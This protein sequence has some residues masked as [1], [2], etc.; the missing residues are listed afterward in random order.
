MFSFFPCL[1]SNAQPILLQLVTTLY[2]D[3]TTLCRQ[4]YEI[5]DGVQLV[6]KINKIKNKNLQAGLGEW[7]FKMS[8]II[9]S[10][11]ESWVKK[12]RRQP[13]YHGSTHYQWRCKS[14]GPQLEQPGIEK[15]NLTVTADPDTNQKPLTP[16]R[17]LTCGWMGRDLGTVAPPTH[18][19]LRTCLI[20]YTVFEE[21]CSLSIATNWTISFKFKRNQ[22]LQLQNSLHL[23]HFPKPVGMFTHSWFA[24]TFKSG[25]SVMDL[26]LGYTSAFAFLFCKWNQTDF[27][28]KDQ[29]FGFHFIA[30]SHKQNK[31]CRWLRG[32]LQL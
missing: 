30:F 18:S 19:M 13:R 31:A 4:V 11:K 16:D 24:N 21:R 22:I 5:V 9:L 26:R 27:I 15:W 25:N 3:K 8:T 23:H 17:E 6:K 29:L 7:N 2:R 14:R 28:C 10:C 12:N 1:F 20:F 32:W